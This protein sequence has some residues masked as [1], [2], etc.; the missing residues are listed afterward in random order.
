LKEYERER[1]VTDL[2]PEQKRHVLQYEQ[3]LKAQEDA[4]VRRAAQQDVMA[5]R[6]HEQM[7]RKLLV[8]K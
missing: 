5:Q 1:A 3:Q 8:E 7:Q 4:R 6:Y 2:S